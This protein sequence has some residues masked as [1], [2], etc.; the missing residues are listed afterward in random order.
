MGWLENVIFKD[1][2]IEGR[3]LELTDKNSL[4]YLSVGLVVRNC[5]IVLKVSAKNLI[6]NQSS[7]IGCTFEVKQELKNHQSWVNASLKGCRFT[8]R[9][10]GC[11]FGYWPDSAS[12]WE[13][14]AIEDCDFSEARLNGCRF[15]GCDPS[16]LRLP[17]WPHFTVLDPVHRAPEL[18]RVP[19]PGRHGDVTV[20]VLNKQ[21]PGT[22]AVTMFAPIIAKEDESTEEEI[23]AHIE[24][25][26][27]IRF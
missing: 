5:T 15:M 21:P 10:S 23:R 22:A 24:R 6:I 14:G 3:R 11:T 9:L 13:H 2:E 18:L 25:F 26:D 20:G 8:G 17:G 19:W 16:T 1:Q 7:F 4:Y 27:F 12:G